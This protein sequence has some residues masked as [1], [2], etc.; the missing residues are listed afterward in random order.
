MKNKGKESFIPW[1]VDRKKIERYTY[2]YDV[3]ELV[4]ELRGVGFEILDVKDG[5]KIVVIVQKM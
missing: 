4:S 5:E 3:N 2:I 1:T